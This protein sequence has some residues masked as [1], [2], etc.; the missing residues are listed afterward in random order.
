M[1]IQNIPWEATKVHSDKIC[2]ALEFT[3]LASQKIVHKHSLN[4]DS[5]AAH[6]NLNYQLKI[7][8]VDFQLQ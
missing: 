1:L 2:I 6:A 7:L 8:W 4:Y 5:H 3:S